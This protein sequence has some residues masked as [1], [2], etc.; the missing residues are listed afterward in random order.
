[1]KLD[2]IYTFNRLRIAKGDKWLTAFRT[3]YGLF[4]YLVTPFG[5][6]NALSSF[7]YFINNTLQPYLDVFY[8]TYINNILVYSNNLAKHQK[9][10]NLILQALRRASLQL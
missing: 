4:K 1:M 3:Q 10:I 9:H 8:T 2:L 6:T 5:L 7:Q